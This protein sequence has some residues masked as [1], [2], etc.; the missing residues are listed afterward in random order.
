MV[1]LIK[2]GF[3]KDLWVIRNTHG[4]SGKPP[5][6]IYDYSDGTGKVATM[7][8]ENRGTKFNHPI[9]SETS[10]RLK[11]ACLFTSEKDANRF[12]DNYLKTKGN[13]GDFYALNVYNSKLFTSDIEETVPIKTDCGWCLISTENPV[14]KQNSEQINK[15]AMRY[16]RNNLS[17]IANKDS[18]EPVDIKSFINH[19]YRK[20]SSNVN[21][22]SAVEVYDGNLAF[23]FEDLFNK[24]TA[25]QFVDD[26]IN[27]N[28]LKPTKIDVL[29]FTEDDEDDPYDDKI[30]GVA[31]VC[32]FD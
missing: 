17:H 18:S 31:V 9:G 30:I 11:Y 3:N 27:K 32:R 24:N 29:D 5:I 13:G 7:R 21:I 23:E 4:S 6:C 1:R 28:N 12:L 10:S 26:F 19:D 22:P 8:Y 14:Y 2:E 20:G 15:D 16:L 25:R